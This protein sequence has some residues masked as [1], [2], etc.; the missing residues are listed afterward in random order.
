M[1]N[2]ELDPRDYRYAPY[3][4]EAREPVFHP[5]GFK[6][7]VTYL[8]VMAFWIAYGLI[9]NYWLRVLIYSYFPGL[10]PHY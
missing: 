10:K 8:A 6:F 4:R 3:R 9:G 5:G 1:P 2:I 7:L